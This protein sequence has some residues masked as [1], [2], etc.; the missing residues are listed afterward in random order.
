MLVSYI[1]YVMQIF[2]VDEMRY[3]P[4]S[5]GFENQI[6]RRNRKKTLSKAERQTSTAFSS[7]VISTV[8]FA[9]HAL[10]II[11]CGL[12]DMEMRTGALGVLELLWLL[13]LLLLLLAFVKCKSGTSINLY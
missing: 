4:C 7:L 1:R 13:L 10:V 3:G 12:D 2:Y 9:I 8:Q 6:E 5:S 11:R